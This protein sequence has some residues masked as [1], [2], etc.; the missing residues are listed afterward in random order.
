M[1][2]PSI[3]KAALCTTEKEKKPPVADQDSLCGLALDFNRG[4][5]IFEGNTLEIVEINVFRNELLN[6]GARGEV[7]S[8]QAF[9]FQ[10]TEEVFLAALS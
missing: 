1:T 4:E 8:V 2:K 5:A 3:F 6:F 9:G 10:D 7:G